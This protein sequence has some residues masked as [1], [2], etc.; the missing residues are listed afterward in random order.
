MDHCD[1]TNALGFQESLSA[2]IEEGFA[3]IAG[4]Q[5]AGKGQRGNQ[6][7]AQANQ[8]L[9]VSFLLKPNHNLLQTQFYL[10]KAI[11]NGILI[12]LQQWASDSLKES[13]PLEIKWPND[14]YLEGKKI[15]GILIESN[16]QAGKWAFSI[17]GIGLNI[18][19]LEFEGLRAT[20]LRLWTQNPQAIDIR[21]IYNNIAIGI[22]N[23]YEAFKGQAFTSIDSNY[24]AKLFQKDAWHSYQ[25]K[26][27]IFEGKIVR[28]NELG[29]IEIERNLGTESYDIKELSFI[30]KD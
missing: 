15:G 4:H 23:Q 14:I 21:E 26:N 22:E 10:S 13:L 9:L 24:H 17:I 11:A 29:L 5:T 16:F 25:D 8:N 3:W 1:S 6:W 28:V 19:Q 30:F 20:S 2:N 27:G 18:N 7:H 12:G